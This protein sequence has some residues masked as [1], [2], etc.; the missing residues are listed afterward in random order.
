[1]TPVIPSCLLRLTFVVS[2]SH[3]SIYGARVAPSTGKAGWSHP[4]NSLYSRLRR[5]LVAASVRL[6]MQHG[7][8]CEMSGVKKGKTDPISWTQKLTDT[9]ID[10]VK[11]GI[12]LTDREGSI[13]FTNKLVSDLLGYRCGSLK[14]KSIEA[15]FLPDDRKV[16]LPNIMKLTKRGKSFQGEAMLCKKNGITFF[17]N[18][19]TALYKGDMPQ[20]YELV[21]FAMQDITYIK[22]M[23]KEY[24]DAERFAG[25]GMITEQ[26]AHQIRNPIVSIGG[27]ALRLVGEKIS[28]EEH[29]HY[30]QIIHGEA[31]RLEH[32]IDRLAEFAQIHPGRYSA[33]SLSQLFEAI[34][35]TFTEH[36]GE[37][38]IRLNLPDPVTLSEKL[39][40]GDFSLLTHA[41]ASIVQN[42]LEAIHDAGEVRIIVDV[43]D[44]DLQI[45]IADNGEGILPEKIQFIY[46]PFFTTKFAYLGLGLTLARRIIHEHK[47]TIEV[48]NA[49]EGGTEFRIILPRERRREIRT[50]PI[51]M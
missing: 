4:L 40:Y 2:S 49:P 3:S 37:N 38:P 18:L 29:A 20:D 21:V 25:L 26:I 30:S 39:I 31:K 51:K 48:A 33:F 24:L 11:T 28:N 7:M 22:Q 47:G 14:G 43:T 34:R 16:F 6:R 12:I 9:L 19:S 35:E 45:R 27:F 8:R 15:F 1:M 36:G 50:K 41:I 5:L 13:L 46:D 42:G 32:I 23:Q 10:V 44:N 17:V